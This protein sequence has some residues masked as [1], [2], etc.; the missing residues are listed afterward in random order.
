MKVCLSAALAAM[1]LA[2]A[3]PALADETVRLLPSALEMPA[4][5]GPLHYSGKPTSWPDKRLGTAYSFGASGMKLDVYVYDGGVTDIPDGADSRT[6]CMEFEN[7]KY[8][9][10]QGGYGGLTLKRQQLA[11]LGPTQ[12]PPLMREAVYEAVI[13]DTPSVSF[14]WITGVSKNFI[15]LRFSANAR[16]RDELED[17]RSAVLTTMGEAIRPHLGP[18][19]AV[20]VPADDEK[21]NTTIT[22]NSTDL[23]NMQFGMLYLGAVAAVANEHPDALPPC[24]GRLQFNF[25]GELAAFTSALNISAAGGD[26]SAFTQRLV[27]ANEAGYLD[28]LVWTYRHQEFWGN[29]PPEEL[30]L[31]PFRKWSRKHLK[32]FKMPEFGYVEARMPKALTIEPVEAVAAH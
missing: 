25:N 1:V 23:D 15:K 26:T 9:V 5:I 21:S 8:G 14:L 19:P 11:R 30:T 31:D 17:A 27:E 12:D 22:I 28:E 4:R 24:G 6:V 20:G 7:A 18:A 2:I 3:A 29:S 13:A 10:E 32:R 16:L